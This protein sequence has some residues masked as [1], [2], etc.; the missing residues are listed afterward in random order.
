MKNRALFIAVIVFLGN[1]L[2]VSQ[3]A[4]AIFGL[5]KCEKFWKKVKAEEIKTTYFQRLYGTYVTVKLYEERDFIKLE[6]AED[7]IYNIWKLGTNNPKC[8]SNTQKLAIKE[9]KSDRFKDILIDL[10]GGGNDSYGSYLSYKFGEYT[11][12]EDR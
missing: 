6:A 5:S 10:N 2:F 11:K 4:Q 8:L 3:P 12:L 1:F 9:M 7:S